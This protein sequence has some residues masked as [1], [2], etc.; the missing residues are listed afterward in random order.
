MTNQEKRQ[1][2]IDKSKITLGRNIY[3]QSLR[4][5]AITPYTDG[6]YYSDCSSY[7]CACYKNAG[8]DIGWTNTTGLETSKYFKTVKTISGKHIDNASDILR[9]ADIIIWNGHV[10]MVH[11]IVN[12]VVNLQGHGSNTPN[13]KTLTN[14]EGWNIPPITIRR[15]FEDDTNSSPVKEEPQTLYCVQ[16]GAFSKKDNAIRFSRQI[17]EHGFDTYISMRNEK[18]YAVQCGAFAKKEN[19]EALSK[20]LKALSF[21]NFI[22]T[23]NI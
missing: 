7:V 10:E 13:I 15:M 4:T 16:C 1:S 12:G 14:A 3:S 18:Y 20:K 2:I 8:Y 19:A 5:Y 6:K 11:S 9:V 23:K 22:T 21:D 17:R